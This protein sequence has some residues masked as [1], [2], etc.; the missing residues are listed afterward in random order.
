MPAEISDQVTQEG[1]Q[2]AEMFSGRGIIPWHGQGTVV[3]GLLTAKEAIEAAH[4]EWEV[5]KRPV[6]TEKWVENENEERKLVTVPI[7]NHKSIV[8]KDNDYP[9][10]VVKDRYNIIQNS[11]CFDFFDS[12][13]GEGQAIYDTAGSLKN[14]RVVWIMAKLS[15][16][17]FI[18]N[19]P[20]DRIDKNI[21]LVT[22]HNS[23]FSLMMQHV[24]TRV[25]CWN[26]LSAALRNC[27][28]QVK[29][30]HTKTYEKKIETAQKAL[31]LTVAYY[32]NLQEVINL[33][34][35]KKMDKRE[36]EDFTRKL[37][38]VKDEED[39]PKQTETVRS[40]VQ[41]LFVN[42]RGNLGRSRWDAMNS[43]T[44]FVDHHRGIRGESTSRFESGLLGSGNNLK[45][46]A[47]ELLV[48]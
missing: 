20:E 7:S 41:D 12:V 10:A 8:R 26:T 18:K 30:R 15:G 29:I 31:Q 14:G 37:F 40:T 5:E 42:G 24:S 21:L 48:S 47:F 9:L 36:M 17:L 16:Q 38:P 11:E 28:N 44:E 3:K 32:D 1:K 39:V 35:D 46:R 34:S 23:T 33:L 6:Y 2:V 43:V 45:N 27:T 25:V 19:N 4:L 22:S 13:V